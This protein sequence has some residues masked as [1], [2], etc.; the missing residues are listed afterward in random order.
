MIMGEE[1]IRKRHQQMTRCTDA[2]LA[3]KRKSDL[4]S[5]MAPETDYEA[6][7]Y[8]LGEVSLEVGDEL[9]E[10]PEDAS[11]K[12]VFCRGIKRAVEL[13][14]ESAILAADV[15]AEFGEPLS[16]V[17]V[18]VDNGLIELRFLKPLKVN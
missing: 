16:A 9:F 14:G 6:L 7:G 15:R 5:G 18:N 2:A 17:V 10:V 12:I 1:H 8:A 4:F 11:E 3:E 13:E